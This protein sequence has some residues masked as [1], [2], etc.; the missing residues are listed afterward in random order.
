MVAIAV[1]ALAAYILGSIPFSYL[2]GRIFAG[3][4]LR[5]HGSG[6]LGASNTFRILGARAAVAVLVLDVAK[7][8]VPVY[9][10]PIANNM[11]GLLALRPMGDHWLMLVAALFAVLG[12]MFS[13]FLRFSGG[14]GIA[15]SAGA[16]MALSPWAF[17]AAFLVWL[18]V[19]VATRIVSAGSI[20]AA[21]ALPVIVLLL[22]RTGL[23]NRHW[24]LLALSCAIAIVVLIKHRGNIS[25][26][27]AGEEPALERRKPNGPR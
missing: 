19:F 13:L 23:A 24:S 22:Q 2:A 17:M 7:G 16:F 10:A 20:S 11:Q 8:F 27:L 1:A 25:R 12:H 6:N 18:L 3:I 15:T 21:L 14:K 5:Q 4:D 9:M 26:L